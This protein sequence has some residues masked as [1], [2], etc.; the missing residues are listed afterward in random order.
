MSTPVDDYIA[1]CRVLGVVARKPT[2]GASSSFATAVNYAHGGPR[3]FSWPRPDGAPGDQLRVDLRGPDAAL[4]PVP[5][6]A[7]RAATT[8]TAT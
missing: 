4:L 8:R 6:A 5:L 3:L 1:T 2:H 7:R